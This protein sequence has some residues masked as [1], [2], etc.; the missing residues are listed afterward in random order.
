MLNTDFWRGRRVFVTGHTGFKG[1]W[2]DLL[3]HSLAARVTG[4]ALAPPTDPSLF[5]L[6]RAAELLDSRLGDVC[7]L[8]ALQ[9]QL[10]A[11]N[12]DVV[13]H[14]AAQS[15]VLAS[16][17][18]PPESYSTN[19]MGTVNVLEAIRRSN[20]RCVVVN[21]TTDK[22]YEN[23][24]WLWGYRESD[25]LGG[26]DPY[27]NSKA[28]AE[29]VSQCYRRSFF[30]VDAH[31]RHGVCIGNARAGNVV[32]G[33]DWTDRQLVPA[34]IAAFSANRPVLLR[35]PRAVRP[36]QHALD[37]L[38]GYLRLAEA[39]AIEGVA[40]SGE[41][42]FGPAIADSLTVSQ[43]VETLAR[44][45]SVAT[46]WLQDTGQHGAEEHQLQLDATKA[47]KL[48]G[49]HGVLSATEALNWTA[50]WY[51]GMQSG[52]DPRALCLTQIERFRSLASY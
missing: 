15:V 39:M 35:N 20:S 2:L 45:W 52:I 1:A 6:T 42:N 28:C 5:S 12:P 10:R 9:S 38:T 24:D 16:Y 46:P 51:T 32:A 48:L 11:A 31:D 19:V 50:E 8:D 3:L 13:I 29:L 43:V 4:Y 44:H 27:S 7:D 14:M 33:G 17:E 34:A 30:P 37:C 26:A 36:W 25:A 40:V 47:A 21:V 41:W 49:W 18:N 22:C 23:Q